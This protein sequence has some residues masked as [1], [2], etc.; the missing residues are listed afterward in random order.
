MQVIRST[1]TAYFDV[2]NCLV[3][4]ESE[5]EFTKAITEGLALIKGQKWVLHSAH[6]QLLKEFHARGFTIIVWS[7]GGADWASTIVTAFGLEA[8]VDLVIGKPDFF[9]DDKC[10]YA[11]MSEDRRTYIND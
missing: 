2:D 5:L 9:I 11:F 7:A 4:S 6:A 10:A 1:K 3:F 8:Y